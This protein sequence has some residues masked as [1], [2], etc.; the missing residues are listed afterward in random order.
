MVDF[1][2]RK[3]TAI[4]IITV[5]TAKRRRPHLAVPASGILGSY[6]P[7]EASTAAIS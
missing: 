4:T 3:M 1:Y 7:L 5:I 6:F 2:F